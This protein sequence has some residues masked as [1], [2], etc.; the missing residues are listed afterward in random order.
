MFIPKKDLVILSMSVEEGIKM[1]VSGGIVTPPDARSD[2]EK[3]IR[4]VATAEGERKTIP[5]ELD[6]ALKAIDQE[7]EFEPEDDEPPKRAAG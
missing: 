7:P 3:K 2:D 4:R 5:Y 1:V 6:T